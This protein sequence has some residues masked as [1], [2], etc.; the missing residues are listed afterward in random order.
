[1][2]LRI[3]G[4]TNNGTSDGLGTLNVNNTSSNS[5]V[6]IGT[7]MCYSKINNKV[8]AIPIKGKTQ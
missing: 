4:N 5:N 8:N 2:A 6:N 7:A 3:D 1:M